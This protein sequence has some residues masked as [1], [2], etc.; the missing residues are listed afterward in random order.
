MAKDKYFMIFCVNYGQSFDDDKFFERY[1]D[2]AK[3]ADADRQKH[4]LAEEDQLLGIRSVKVW[5][6]YNP[7]KYKHDEL[8]ESANDEL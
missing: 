6:Q 1:E 8:K 7:K 4:A 5:R 2:A 3:C